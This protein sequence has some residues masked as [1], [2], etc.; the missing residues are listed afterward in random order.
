MNISQHLQWSDG[1]VWDRLLEKAEMVPEV[2]EQ[3]E[4]ARRVP[5]AWEMPLKG[6]KEVAV[7][8]TA[9]LKRKSTGC[10]RRRNRSGTGPC[11]K[12]FEKGTVFLPQLL[13]SIEAAKAAF[14]SDKN[15]MAGSL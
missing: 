12:G 1:G 7:S 10:D 11:R 8:V 2:L 14:G 15:A 6:L 9:L 3:P 13:M 5:E 4:M